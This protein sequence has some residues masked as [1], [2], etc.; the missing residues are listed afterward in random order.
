[1]ATRIGVDIGGTF[2]DLVYYDDETGEIREAKVPTTPAA[3]E[4]GVV[5]A[6]VQAVPNHLIRSA[7]Y[8]LHGTTVGLNA[9][10]ERRGAVV[11]LLATRGFRD[12]LEIRRGDRG[13]MYNLFWHQPPP[14]VPRRLRWPVTERMLANGEEHTPLDDADIGEAVEL[15]AKEGVTS[16]AVAF[17][18]AYANPAHELQAEEALRRHGFDGEVSLSHRVSGEYREYERTSTTVI[19]AFVRGRM[20]NYLRRLASSLQEIGFNGQFLI[21]RSGSGS[22]SFEEAEERPFE[23][24]MSGPVAGAEGAGELARTLDI[25]DLITADVGGTSFDTCLILGGRP[26]VMYEGVVEGMP[27]QTPWVDVRS[28]GAGGG[29]IAHV[30]I[31]NLLKVGP[32]SAGADPGP[33]S[34]GKGGL[35]ATTTD[36]AAVLGMLGSG[37]LASGIVLDIE[38]AQAAL[39]PVANSLGYSVDQ[40]A[41]GILTIASANM[42]NAIRE[43]TVEQG[44]DPRRLTLLP[45]GGAGPLMGTLLARELDI[46]QIVLPPYAGNFSAWGLLGADMVQAAAQTRIMELNEDGVR[47]VNIL[48]SQLFESLQNRSALLGAERSVQEARV[49]LRYRGQEHWLSVAVPVENGLATASPAEI[50]DA[51]TE[52]YERTFGGS[53]DEAVEIVS[54]RATLRRKLPRR[55]Q[56]VRLPTGDEPSPKGSCEA[57]SFTLNERVQFMVIDRDCLALSKPLPGP[58]IITEST[59]TTYLDAGWEARVDGSGSLFVTQVGGQA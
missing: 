28:I 54:T 39:R 46:R 52:E 32:R 43:I 5:D 1:M 41:Q 13:E 9:L 16:V 59:A 3:P 58:A 35:E 34:Y 4:K 21:T 57:Y 8:F 25:G 44:V 30:D 51:F 12:V 53:M 55:N 29:S 23:T 27:V 36:A 49:D 14:L 50:R 7:E 17:L 48:L 45:F 37:E 56:S 10:L 31:G 40:L 11:G 38:G 22:M 47:E 20:S 26:Q 15:F 19:D 18:N 42:A 6:V 2:T 33:A 24:I